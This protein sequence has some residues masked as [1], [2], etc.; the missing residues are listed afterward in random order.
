VGDFRLRPTERLKKR[1][2]FDAAFERGRRFRGRLVMLVAA[3]NDVPHPRL[4]IIASRRVGGAVRRNR[5]KRL[6][7]EAFRLNKDRLR[8]PLDVVMI[9][10]PRLPEMRFADVEA[11]V[12]SLFQK[13][14]SALG[15]G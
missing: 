6:L 4:G 9:A 15:D 13:V 7:R 3:P 10:S 12:R 5:A 11:E 14:N 2:E 8:A 1:R